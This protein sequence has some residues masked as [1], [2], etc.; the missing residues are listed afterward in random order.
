M[1]I[2]LPGAAASHPETRHVVAS[3]RNDQRLLPLFLLS[4]MAEGFG[5]Q[6]MS[7][8]PQDGD[9]FRRQSPKRSADRCERLLSALHRLTARRRNRIRLTHA[10]RSIDLSCRTSVRHSVLSFVCLRNWLVTAHRHLSESALGVSLRQ[11]YG[12]RLT[13]RAPFK[14]FDTDEIRR[15]FDAVGQIADLMSHGGRNEDRLTRSLQ[16]TVWSDPL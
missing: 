12:L 2:A 4:I 16:D 10:Q 9:Q 7:A 11:W 6:A 8:T 13:T 1:R 14:V 3:L 15:D 5:L